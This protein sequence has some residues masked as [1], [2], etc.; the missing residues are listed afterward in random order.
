MAYGVQTVQVLVAN[1]LACSGSN[2]ILSMLLC[3]F[4]VHA[5]SKAA[6]ANSNGKTTLAPQH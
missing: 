5:S 2:S 3:I 1:K 4:I 6:T